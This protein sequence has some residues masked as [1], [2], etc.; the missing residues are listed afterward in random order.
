M[1]YM[2]MVH[3]KEAEVAKLPPEEM[4]RVVSAHAEYTEAL[5]KAGVLVQGFRLRPGA[6]MVRIYQP[7]GPSGPRTTFDGPHAEM[8]EVVGGYYI[9]DCA[10]REE[11][12]AWS[13]KCPMWDADTLELRPVWEM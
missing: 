6:E 9:L 7:Q 4:D 3:H 11:A 1:K 12:V 8:R 5:R 2:L 10:T 13:K